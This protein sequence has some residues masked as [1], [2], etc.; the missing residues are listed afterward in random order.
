MTKFNFL[1]QHDASG[2]RLEFAE[3]LNKWWSEDINARNKL[4]AEKIK[5]MLMSNDVMFQP[6]NEESSGQYWTWQEYRP[7][8]ERRKFIVLD[9]KHL[10]GP[11]GTVIDLLEEEGFEIKRVKASD[12][13]SKV[14][15]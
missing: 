4:F 8:N 13:L 12:P 2:E 10:A 14:L 9:I 5:A 6:K 3:A 1:F 7:K 11:Q 15:F